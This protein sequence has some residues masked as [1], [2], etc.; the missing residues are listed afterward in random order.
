MTKKPHW[1]KETTWL[2]RFEQALNMMLEEDMP[3]HKRHI[4]MWLM[5]EQFCQTDPLQD[6]CVSNARL[7]W[8]QGIELIDAAWKLADTPAEGGEHEE[9]LCETHGDWQD[10][11]WPKEYR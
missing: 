1:A 6:W 10:F 8:C 7:S 5:D 11:K 3:V 4:R 9:R 2:E